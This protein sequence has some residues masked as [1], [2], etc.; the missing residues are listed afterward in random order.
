[1]ELRHLRT[2]RVI[3]SLAF[4]LLA[5]FMFIDL[6]G[7]L[8]PEVVATVSALQFGPA[9]VR[10]F[11]GLTL[12]VCALAGV[13][14]LTVTFGRVYCSTICPLGT[15]QD[16]FSRLNRKRNSRRRFLYRRQNYL[17]HYGVLGLA[18]ALACGGSMLLLNL[19]EP[20]SNFGRASVFFLR[21]LVVAINNLLAGALDLLHVYMLYP[22][23]LRTPAPAS[24]LVPIAFILTVFV[25]S[26][27]GGRLFC[28]LLC[29]AGALLGILSRI[30][31][32]RIVI[33]KPACKDCGLCEKVCKAGCIDS[34][35]MHVDFSA[36]VSCFN[37]LHAC[38]TTGLI[39]RGRRG[40]Y[41]QQ[42]VLRSR[43]RRKVL[44]DGISAAAALLV[45]PKDS[46]KTLLPAPTG[47]SRSTLPVTPPGSVGIAHFTSRCTAC[48]LCVSTCPTQVLSPSFLEF[49][50]DGI[51]QPRMDYSTGTCTYDC[52][53]C[54][55]VCPS[56]AIL[57][58]AQDEKKLV[59][60]GKAKFVKED[61]IVVTKK[62]ECGACSEHC[63]TK[64]VNMVK[65]DGLFLPV[66][67][68]ELCIGCGSCEHPCPSTPNKA[69]YV[70]ANP[71]HGRA[72]KPEPKKAVPQIKSD[73]DFP[74]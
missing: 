62:T 16:L 20:F 6:S 40:D 35:R 67:N 27:R 53:K 5:A 14:L 60:I 32:F 33:D 23:P 52:V 38:P 58:L 57:P 36:C 3:V 61:C 43:R 9:L 51:F 29:P 70:E 48:H 56:G 55:S 54:G 72:K 31:L 21:P 1:M 2:V 22:V 34:V 39:Y 13:I 49:G 41:P 74:F 26:Y 66:L 65:T 25:L 73:A 12:S 42:Q 17:L 69:I 50:V 46:L 47:K 19:L 37:C 10:L 63:P 71:I 7:L 30:A 4:F 18:A 59:Q 24:Y 45:L 8:P 68:E 64:A 44:R 28:N 15:L 11:S